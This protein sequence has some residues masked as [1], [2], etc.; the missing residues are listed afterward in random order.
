MQGAALDA[1]EWN[2]KGFMRWAGIRLVHAAEGRSRVEL[3][4]VEEHR[5]GVGTSAINGA[6]LAYLH[7]VAQG[8]AIRSCF[9]SDI[10]SLATINLNIEYQ[11]ALF[12]ERVVRAEGCAVRVGRGIAFAE[13]EVRDDHAELCSRAIGSFHLRREAYVPR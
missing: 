11:R 4:V 6:L 7:D 2:A 12:V 9:R 13:S 1:G 5:G 8:L 3:T 10:A